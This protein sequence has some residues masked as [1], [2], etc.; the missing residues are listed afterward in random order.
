MTARPRILLVED[1]QNF[2]DV[3]KNYLELSKF[4]VDLARDGNVG[5]SKFL[6]NRYE[7]CILDVMMPYKDGFTLAQ[8]IRKKSQDIP[9]IFLTARNQKEDQLK[10]FKLG[11]D[12]Y[13]TKPF[14]TEI[15]LYK[16]KAIIKRKALPEEEVV[17]QFTVG[18]Y[19]FDSK[20]RLL[21][22]GE[23]S[24]KLSPKETQLLKMLC[25]HKNDVT[26]RTKALLEIWKSED[27]FTT[28]SMDVYIAK[29]RKYLKGDSSIEI[30]NIHS[31]GYS[32]VDSCQ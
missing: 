12:D 16:I 30:R 5:L 17:H 22:L 20:L 28:R 14:D 23:D 9:L 7:L 26:P 3:L 24:R 15:L 6:Q 4:Q 19:N 1:E 11:A 8:E 25:Q 18:N 31:E 29:L 2:G 27:Y 10:G 13:I 32:L 21:R